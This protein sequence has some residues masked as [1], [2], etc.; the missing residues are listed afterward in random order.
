MRRDESNIG[1][2]SNTAEN[3][4][5]RARDSQNQ[6]AA[7]FIAA[8]PTRTRNVAPTA[9]KADAG[10]TEAIQCSNTGI[11]PLPPSSSGYTHLALLEL[12]RLKMV[13]FFRGLAWARR[14]QQAK[15]EM[16]A[17]PPT[18]SHC[19]TPHGAPATMGRLRRRATATPPE[20]AAGGVFPCSYIVVLRNECTC[21]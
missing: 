12:K 14:P 6:Q 17:N 3:R 8:A 15:V 11:P 9:A 19:K 2:N 4:F 18:R 13:I 5:W 20:V 10:E 1:Q 21:A 7:G 16:P